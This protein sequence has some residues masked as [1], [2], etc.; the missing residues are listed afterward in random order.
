MPLH[1]QQSKQS[2]AQ[3]RFKH[4]SPLS[5]WRN[6]VRRRAAHHAG[7]IRPAILLWALGVPIPLVLLFVL[8]RGCVG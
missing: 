4:V 7:K 5:P 3:P 2:T 8:I 1:Q 6:R